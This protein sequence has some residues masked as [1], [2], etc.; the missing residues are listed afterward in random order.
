MPQLYR[1]KTSGFIRIRADH[2]ETAAILAEPRDNALL[3]VWVGEQGSPVMDNGSA[4]Y[5]VAHQNVGG[6]QKLIH[7]TFEEQYSAEV[8]PPPATLPVPIFLIGDVPYLSQVDTDT[9]EANDC[10]EVSVRMVL[11]HRR[12]RLG[13][14]GQPPTTGDIR[15]V[16]KKA[17]GTLTSLETIQRYFGLFGV[18]S[19]YINP[20]DTTPG[21][22]RKLLD[23]GLPIVA[24]IQVYGAFSD[25]QDTF[26]GGH[27]AVVTG[28]SDQGVYINDPLR[29]GSR[30]AEGVN[31]HVPWAE[32]VNARTQYAVLVTGYN[33][34]PDDPMR[35][36]PAP[37]ENL[38]RWYVA[39]SMI[40]DVQ[41]ASAKEALA[42]LSV[43]SQWI[44][45]DDEVIE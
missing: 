31:L 9:P 5:R 43:R 34:L 32:W 10:G 21:G 19:R 8:V 15:A 13:L 23:E 7:D 1:L 25:R 37:V 44:A 22:L 18:N 41:I 17:P 35:L 45:I 6:W 3:S 40:E 14:P 33:L 26:T 4:W 24:L 30:K 38:L 39:I 20:P 11:G 27:I 2:S 36:P 16:W 12:V 42:R 29:W 28:Y